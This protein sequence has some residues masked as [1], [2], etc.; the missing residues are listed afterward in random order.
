[1]CSVD[2]TATFFVLRMCKNVH[3]FSIYYRKLQNNARFLHIRSTVFSIV[4]SSC[5]TGCQLICLAPATA[6]EVF[7]SGRR[8]L[9]RRYDICC[10]CNITDKKLSCVREAAR[11]FKSMNISLSHS[12]SFEMTPLRRACVSPYIY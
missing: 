10:H 11:Y 8:C 1:M 12:R 2:N 5:L 3:S 7:V 4:V 6:R 9:L